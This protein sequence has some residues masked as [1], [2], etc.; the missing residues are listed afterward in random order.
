MILL[1]IALIILGLVFTVHILWGLGMVF[2]VVGVVL[3]LLGSA[4]RRIGGRAHY[5]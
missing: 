3:A 5:F 4:G 2:V 1:G